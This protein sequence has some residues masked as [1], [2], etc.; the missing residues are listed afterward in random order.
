MQNMSTRILKA[1]H[2]AFLDLLGFS[3]RLESTP[4]ENIHLEYAAL[5]D[6]AQSRVFDSADTSGQPNHNFAFARFLFDS[7]VVVSNPTE[8]E[9]GALNTFKFISSVSWLLQIGIER[10]M[11]FRGCLSHGDVLDD[12]ARGVILSPAFPEL[13]IA[14]KDFNW[15][16]AVVLPR[17]VEPIFAGLHNSKPDELPQNAS[18]FFVRYDA[19]TKS[20]NC[21]SWWCLNWVHLCTATSIRRGVASLNEAKQHPTREFVEFIQALPSQARG[22]PEQFRP[23]TE[24]RCQTAKRGFRLLFLDESGAPVDLPDGVPF[25]FT[26]V[27]AAPPR[28]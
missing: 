15:S 4:L 18:N 23:A 12:S 6:E 2:I 5:M 14:E 28:P 10:G 26:F 13:V 7:L 27:I 8:E 25:N 3:H 22:L 24:V 21:K 11:P 20:G 9:T 16:G 1:R 17:A 19:P